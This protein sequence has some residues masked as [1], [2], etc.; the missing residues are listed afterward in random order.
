VIQAIVVVLMGVGV[1]TVS[2][3]EMNFQAGAYTRPPVSST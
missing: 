2:D 1:A 3:V